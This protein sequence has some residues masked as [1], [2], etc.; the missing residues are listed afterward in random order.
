MTIGDDG[1]GTIDDDRPVVGIR[2]LEY[3]LTQAGCRV[4]N[5]GSQSSQQEC[6]E[7]GL[8]TAADAILVSSV[9]GLGEID[10]RGFGDKCREAGLADVVRYVDGNLVVTS[11]TQEWEEAAARFRAMGFD[12][13]YALVTRP[14]Q[15]I[16]DLRG[17]L[18][19]RGRGAVKLA[20]LRPRS[21]G[22]RRRGA[23]CAVNYRRPGCG[24]AWGR[25]GG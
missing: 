23:S 19:V 1:L 14:H 3:A 17:A 2:L 7:A 18:L 24:R 11:Q 15:V 4:V 21:G 16:D 12:R 6:L 10:C 8:E 9:Y 22:E 25:E 13:V 20:P 5:S